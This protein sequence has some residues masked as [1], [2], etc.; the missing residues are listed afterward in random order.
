[1]VAENQIGIML[2]FDFA[3]TVRLD[4]GYMYEMSANVLYAVNVILLHG[5]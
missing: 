3:R 5:F 2:H 4:I 1:M